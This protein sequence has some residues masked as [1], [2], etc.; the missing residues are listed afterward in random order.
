M[1]KGKQ[2]LKNPKPIGS[3]VELEEKEAIEDI[4]WREHKTL[5]EIT[6]KAIIEYIKNHAEGNDTFKIDKFVENPDFM[7][8]PTLL[9]NKEKWIKYYQDSNDKDRT[10]VRIAHNEL[11]KVMDMVHTNEGKKFTRLGRNV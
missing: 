1:T 7:A 6:R 8:V 9:D 2:E 4:G 3:V 11:G 5:S 10:K